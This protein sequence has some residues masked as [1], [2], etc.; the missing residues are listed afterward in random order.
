[1]QV[2]TNLGRAKAIEV[3]GGRILSFLEVSDLPQVRVDIR[4]IEINRSKLQSLNPN[5]ALMTSNFRQ[6]SLNPAQ[7]A[8]AAQGGQAARVGSSGAAIQNVLSFLN[9]GLLN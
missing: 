2:R 9:G 7:S 4:L 8:A 3:A 5:S 6:P 1:N